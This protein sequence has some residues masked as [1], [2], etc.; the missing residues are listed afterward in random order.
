MGGDGLLGPGAVELV[1]AG[2]AYNK[3]MRAHKLTLQSLWRLLMPSLLA[4]VAEADADC[5]ACISRMAADDD[6]QTI[7]ELITFLDQDKFR[8]LLADF[9]ESR[10]DVNFSFWWQY[11]DMVAILL[12][13]TRAQRDGI[14]ELH[15]YSFSLMLPYFKRYDHL[16]YAR[17]GPVYLVEMH[18]LPEPVLSEFKRGNFV[19]KRSAHKFN[20]VDP[21]QAMEWINGTGKKGGGI[22]G[23]TKTTSTLCRWTLSFNLRSHI[24]ELT[25]EMYSLY[26]G[27]TD[28]HNEA[29]KSR[30]KRDND[31]ESSLMSTFQGFSVFS[32]VS[33]PATLQNLVTKDLA[34]EV[35]QESLLRA[36]RL[37]QQEVKKFV[38]DRL[39]VAEQCDKPDV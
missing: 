24:A 15:L 30:Q 13:Y 33:H 9:V 7:P 1:L 17:W 36:K 21:D 29:T 23:I 20:Q 2:K 19:V 16:N 28:L 27:N 25:H 6:S 4:F 14:W 12:Q 26:R 35:I 8:K 31:D 10:Y 37:G 3:A 11:M 38:Q 18:Q 32:S 22:V 39:I 5:H 34:T